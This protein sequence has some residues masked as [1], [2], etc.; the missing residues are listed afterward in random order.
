LARNSAT[1]DDFHANYRDYFA[2]AKI[3]NSRP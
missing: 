2:P 1:V 3:E